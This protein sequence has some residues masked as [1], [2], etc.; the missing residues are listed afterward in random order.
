MIW[1]V[2]AGT[3]GYIHGSFFETIVGVCA[4]NGRPEGWFCRKFRQFVWLSMTLEPF[5]YAFISR[6]DIVVYFFFV[7]SH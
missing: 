2:F 6:F 4:A 3:K 1:P 7:I 5:F